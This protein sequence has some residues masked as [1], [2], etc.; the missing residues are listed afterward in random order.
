MMTQQKNIQSA[1]RSVCRGSADGGSTECGAS[2]LIYRAI[3]KAPIEAQPFLSSQIF[4]VGGSTKFWGFKER[5]WADLR[6]L[7]P[8]HWPIHIFQHEDPQHSPWLGASNWTQDDGVYLQFS[9]S[10]QQFLETGFV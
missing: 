8:E 7:L 2:E 5:L 3:C 4:L 9:V 1:S 6:A 10:R